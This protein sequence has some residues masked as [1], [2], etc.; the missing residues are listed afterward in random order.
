M[1]KIE[2]NSK[3]AYVP[4]HPYAIKINGDSALRKNCNA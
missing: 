4:D 3:W 2:H 1:K